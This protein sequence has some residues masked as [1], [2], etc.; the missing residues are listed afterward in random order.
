MQTQTARTSDKSPVVTRARALLQRPPNRRSRATA[1]DARAGDDSD[2]RNDRD[3]QP[4]R[5]AGDTG[6]DSGGGESDL[7]GEA[8]NSD[9]AIIVAWY[10]ARRREEIAPRLII[11]ERLDPLFPIE[12]KADSTSHI[13]EPFASGTAN[14]GRESEANVLYT[15][16]T[17]H[18]EISKA[19]AKTVRSLS[20]LESRFP[21]VLLDR[22]RN[23]RW[24]L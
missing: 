21:A 24:S 6:R 11:P 16:A 7:D 1:E 22:L 4:D 13:M 19:L 5:A 23:R 9:Q 18:T 2:E 8:A 12:F 15:N 14:S 10:E 20:A 17:Y 3:R